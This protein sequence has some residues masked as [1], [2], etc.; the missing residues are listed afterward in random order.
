MNVNKLKLKH[1]YHGML[2]MIV[3]L[4]FFVF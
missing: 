1:E 2:I 3:M 4:Y